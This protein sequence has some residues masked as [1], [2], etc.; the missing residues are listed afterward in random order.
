MKPAP[1]PVNQ[2]KQTRRAWLLSA[3]VVGG[4]LAYVFLIFLPGR[5]ATAALRLE[6]DQKRQYVLL[7]AGTA[8]KIAAAEDELKRANQFI[9]AWHNTAPTEARIAQVFGEI[10]RHADAA[11][12]QI[13]R[14]EPLAVEKLAH[15]HRIPVSMAYEGSFEQIFAFLAK[16]ETLPTD[17]WVVDL[18]LAPVT[19]GSPSLRCELTLAFFA[20]HNEISD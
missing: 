7:H 15:L 9:Q 20:G 1:T 19:A 17:F 13:V 11:A 3:V 6:L 2:K 16:L 4:V 5:R 14:F 10:T 12:V 18:E 8:S